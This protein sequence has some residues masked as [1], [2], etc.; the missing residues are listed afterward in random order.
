MLTLNSPLGTS[1]L[2]PT[3]IAYGCWRL[4]G[5]EG[6]PAVELADGKRAV[7]AA[8]EA[9]IN[10]FD[11]ADIYG[12]SECERVFGE[13]L[14]DIPG[15]RERLI[16]ATKCGICPPWDGRQHSYNSSHEHIVA[17]VEDSLRRL[18][19]E[20]VDLL[21]IHRP[22]YLG[23]PGEIVGAFAHL[24]EQ[25][26]VRWFGVSNFKPSQIAALQSA[27]GAPLIV[28]QVEVS[29]GALA[30][31]DDGT[32]DHCL[33]KQITP[34][35]WSPLGKGRLLGAAQHE[36]DAQLFA[37]LDATAARHNVT[38]SA[39]A[40]AWL[41]RHPA[42]MVPIIGTINPVHLK[43]ALAADTVTLSRDEWYELLIAARGAKLP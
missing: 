14:R 37:V 11:H 29:L 21:M 32:L 26:K 28:N 8:I 38:R 4:A 16:I 17:S 30:C 18:G 23:D 1:D 43:E 22:D 36:H 34:L 12:R 2:V 5:S 20:Y 42:K 6:G 27:M 40:L 10:F 35:A 41:L 25:G 33:E 3:R 13:A 24:H 19:V 31:L 39:I 15:T 9:G 7:R